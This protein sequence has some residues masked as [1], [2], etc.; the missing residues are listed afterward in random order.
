MLATGRMP[1]GM[2]LQQGWGLRPGSE[3]DD[4]AEAEALRGT[5]RYYPGSRTRFPS[6]RSSAR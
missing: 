3:L 2:K 6:I 1:E 4:R 5:I